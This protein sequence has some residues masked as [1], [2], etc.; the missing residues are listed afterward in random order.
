MDIFVYGANT[1]GRHGKGAAKH[2]HTHYGAVYGKTGLQGASYGVITKELRANYPRV[3]L[4]RVREEIEL[5][6]DCCR[7]HPEHRFVCT[8]FGTGLAGFTHEQICSLLMKY[9][10]PANIVLPAEWEAIV[11]GV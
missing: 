10:L 9:E 5:L 8:P 1:E 7:A 6:L 2:A 4:G 11:T 3:T